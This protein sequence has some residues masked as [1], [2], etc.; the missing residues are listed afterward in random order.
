MFCERLEDVHRFPKRPAEPGCRL[1]SGV[2]D[3]DTAHV[4]DLTVSHAQAQP[5]PKDGI[6]H[7]LICADADGFPVC[8]HSFWDAIEG[9]LTARPLIQK[10]MLLD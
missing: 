9:I 10:R 6:E 2:E 8:K 3:I 4:V 1:L 7:S 5:V